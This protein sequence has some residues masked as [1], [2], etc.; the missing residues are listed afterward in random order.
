MQELSQDEDEVSLRPV[1]VMRFNR[2]REE[3]AA[4][5][6]EGEGDDLVDDDDDA[7]AMDEEQPR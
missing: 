7:F 4:P 2:E 3:D 6:D 5:L 1:K